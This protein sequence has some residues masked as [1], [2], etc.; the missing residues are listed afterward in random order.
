MSAAKDWKQRNAGTAYRQDWETPP[1]LFAKID[2]EFHFT[3]D[4]AANYENRKCDWYFDRIA[5]G[6]RQSWGRNIVWLNPPYDA[7]LAEWVAKAREA[8]EEGATV[9]CLIPARTDTRWWH[10]HVEGRAEVRFIK[11][12]IRF[13][14]AP[15]NAPFPSCLVVFRP[16]DMVL[17]DGL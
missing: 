11:G 2:A 6:L 10:A 15:Y 16:A 5:D 9:V 3:I 8:S 1:E 13:V 12:R 17:T 7:S 4:A 14:G